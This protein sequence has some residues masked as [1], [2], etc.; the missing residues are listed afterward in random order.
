MSILSK[1]P[2]DILVGECLTFLDSSTLLLA[3]AS[4]S[5]CWRPLVAETFRRF[6]SL[7]FS[8]LQRSHRIAYLLDTD[9][10]N[11][12]ESSQMSDSSVLPRRRRYN[13]VQ[14]LRMFNRY[15]SQRFQFPA[16]CTTFQCTTL[17]LDCRSVL[18]FVEFCEQAN[19]YYTLFPRLE[20]IVV[21]MELFRTSSSR[22]STS[23]NR[24]MECIATRFGNC[25]RLSVRGSL[26]NS[27]VF[28]SVACGY[29][30]LRSLD[31]S[32]CEMPL[33][34][35]RVFG[36]NASSTSV[37]GAKIVSF[38]SSQVGQRVRA[39]EHVKTMLEDQLKGLSGTRSCSAFPTRPCPLFLSLVNHPTL[40]FVAVRL[41]MFYDADAYHQ[42]INHRH[43]ERFLEL[44][45]HDP[46]GTK[47]MLTS[48]YVDAISCHRRQY[49]DF[50]VDVFDR[51]CSIP[52]ERLSLVID[53]RIQ[54]A[55][56]NTDS[57]RKVQHRVES[58]TF[59]EGCNVSELCIPEDGLEPFHALR[60]VKISARNAV[61]AEQPSWDFVYG[62]VLQC[63]SLE[64]LTLS[65]IS[66]TMQQLLQLS[67]KLSGAT[68]A[69]SH[70]S[71]QV[72]ENNYSGLL[73][74]NLC[75]IRCCSIDVRLG[76]FNSLVTSA[77]VR[78]VAS[79]L[80]RIWSPRVSARFQ[81]ESNHGLHWTLATREIGQVLY[82]FDDLSRPLDYPVTTS[83]LSAE[84]DLAGE[85]LR[86][87][88]SITSRVELGNMSSTSVCGSSS[89]GDL[90]SV[91][92]AGMSSSDLRKASLRTNRKRTAIPPNFV[93]L[94]PF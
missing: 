19:L 75:N 70:L 1:L 25:T 26:Y 40:E 18:S 28:P 14:L 27:F 11:K 9:A 65:R 33:E 92:D 16:S 69:I 66:C 52:I 5:L 81:L 73:S 32:N 64:T 76:D 86:F 30:G 80:F 21:D 48:W 58:L 17:V 8:N 78:T 38:L 90:A 56:F 67:S 60:H 24:L 42:R 12:S 63:P 57:F 83:I 84:A 39:A 93:P 89:K 6:R 36:T 29:V 34:S 22:Y 7:T 3:V 15:G 71:V 79:L 87:D 49:I 13:T 50:D 77:S 54:P 37:C 41:S 91:S 31:L 43:A 85:L 82:M 23:E 59:E 88:I 47:E 62:L 45:E 68:V 35:S 4:V 72:V 61:Q 46:V 2:F 20:E 51:F 55:F 94:T 53:A 10:K 74:A 44:L